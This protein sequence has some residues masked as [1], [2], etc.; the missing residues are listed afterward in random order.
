M[1]FYSLYYYYL[2]KSV[3]KRSRESKSKTSLDSLYYYLTTSVCKKEQEV[4]KLPLLLPVR[5]CLEEEEQKQ[6]AFNT[7]E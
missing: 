7:L 5:V 1:S 2:P 4:Q 3:R 6:D